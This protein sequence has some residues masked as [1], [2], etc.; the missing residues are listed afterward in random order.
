MITTDMRYYDYFI[1][2]EADDYGQATCSDE[3][4]GKVKIAINI[5]TQSIQ[6]NIL[7]K[8]CAYTGLTQD[9]SIDDTYVIKYGN[10]KL[11]V[12]Y[13]NPKGRYIQVFLGEYNG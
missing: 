11:K 8:N 12:Q 5:A 13:I 10:D 4:K 2:N 7:Y 3:A 9:K 1:F 6:D